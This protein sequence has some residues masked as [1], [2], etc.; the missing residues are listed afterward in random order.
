MAECLFWA[1]A[2]VC[3]N[4]EVLLSAI[5]DILC[6]KGKLWHT[7]QNSFIDE[8]GDQKIYYR[9]TW[10][11][12]RLRQYN[13]H[14]DFVNVGIFDVLKPCQ[15]GQEF[16]VNREG[17]H[18][19]QFLSAADKELKI[20]HDVVGLMEDF[21][22]QTASIYTLFNKL[23]KTLKTGRFLDSLHNFKNFFDFHTAVFEYKD[24]DRV[25]VSKPYR[26][27]L[28]TV[29]K[30]HM[31]MR[32]YGAGAAR[33]LATR[34][35]WKIWS[36]EDKGKNPLTSEDDMICLMRE[37]PFKFD[38][39]NDLIISL[40]LPTQGEDE[41]GVEVQGPL[42]SLAQA[43]E[44]IHNL[45]S[46]QSRP[47]TL[48]AIRSS[49]PVD[50]QVVLNE[51]WRMK[52]IINMNRD[53][54]VFVNSY[55]VKMAEEHDDP[56][57]GRDE[58]EDVQ[59]EEFC[60]RDVK[61]RDAV[62][63]ALQQ[64]GTGDDFSINVATLHK[65]LSIADNASLLREFKSVSDLEEFLSA[66]GDFVLK[67]RE[68][69]LKN[70][71]CDDDVESVVSSVASSVAESVTK[72][73]KAL[74]ETDVRT[75]E[76]L[77]LSG[78]YT[79]E[80][81]MLAYVD[82]KNHSKGNK[83]YFKLEWVMARFLPKIKRQLKDCH[84]LFDLIRNHHASKFTAVKRGKQKLI[85]L[86]DRLAE[87]PMEETMVEVIHNLFKSSGMSRIPAG[88][89]FELLSQ[90]GKLRVKSVM[91]FPHFVKMHEDDFSV[92]SK[93]IIS[94][95]TLATTVNK[96]NQSSSSM[97][98]ESLS[99]SSEVESRESSVVPSEHG[100]FSEQVGPLNPDALA[101][102]EELLNSAPFTADI[103]K[104]AFYDHK[105]HSKGNKVYFKLDWVVSFSPIQRWISTLGTKLQ[106][107][108]DKECELLFKTINKYHS[109]E[110][111]LFRSIAG[112]KKSL[113]QTRCNI[114]RLPTEEETLSELHKQ[115]ESAGKSTISSGELFSSL[116]RKGRLRIQGFS[117]F[118][119]FHSDDFA[120]A[121]KFVK[122]KKFK[123]PGGPCG[124]K[125]ASSKQNG[126]SDVDSVAGS[127]ASLG[128]G[129]PSEQIKGLEASA[130]RF[131]EDL[132][133]TSP[134]KVDS[135]KIAYFDHKD[136]SKGNKIYFRLDWVFS[137]LHP[138]VNG[139]IKDCGMLLKIISTYH[140][141][142]FVLFKSNAGPEKS[143][144][145]TKRFMDQLPSDESVV[146][147]LHRAFVIAGQASISSATLFELLSTGGQLRIKN[148][149][150]FADFVRFHPEEFT[151]EDDDQNVRDKKFFVLS[152]VHISN[153]K[154]LIESSHCTKVNSA[155]NDTDPN[156]VI[157]LKLD[158]V[159]DRIS[160][161]L[162][163]PD[164]MT[165]G[166]KLG[167]L[168]NENHLAE[169]HVIVGGQGKSWLIQTRKKIESL[170]PEMKVAEEVKKLVLGE[171]NNGLVDFSSV[172]KRLSNDALVRIRN[173][174]DWK[175]FID[176]H[177]IA[178]PCGSVMA[179]ETLSLSKILPDKDGDCVG[180]V[181]PTSESVTRPSK[182]SSEQNPT[183]TSPSPPGNPIAPPSKSTAGRTAPFAVTQQ[184][185]QQAQ[186]PPPFT[187]K[188]AQPCDVEMVDKVPPKV[189]PSQK[190]DCVS[191]MLSTSAM[192]TRPSES[193]SRENSILTSPSPPVNL[194]GKSTTSRMAPSAASQQA[195]QQARPQHPLAHKVSR[196]CDS[197]MVD[198]DQTLSNSLSSQTGDGVACTRPEHGLVARPSELRS[199]SNPASTSGHTSSLPVS[200][201]SRL[202]TSTLGRTA[203]VATATQSVGREQQ[204][205]FLY[206]GRVETAAQI[207]TGVPRS[208]SVSYGGPSAYAG[209]RLSPG[210]ARSSG[211]TPVRPTTSKANCVVS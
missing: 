115:F 99:E 29:N 98:Q 106:G 128:G 9:K 20:V 165:N 148:A 51:D 201:V 202:N 23:D 49:L 144:M 177:K 7:P 46:C 141:N 90:K 52:Q 156:S 162:N 112:A 130:V 41:E 22:Q 104:V 125:S 114:D 185:N 83:V 133:H 65:V 18:L 67:G 77:L 53:S 160:K 147:E 6:R 39:S 203:P 38:C 166:Q 80:S 188:V 173:H 50:Y 48:H 121:D 110:I 179:N 164:G 35:L 123:G 55:T 93:N 184:A 34:A 47:M 210:V 19:T 169:F 26:D 127:V 199:G 17:I 69:S 62:K 119:K 10:V 124:K 74:S 180:G 30:M 12:G 1:M 113:I 15:E 135:C 171:G 182:S 76:G 92:D 44:E 197:G 117:D 84:E 28:A 181:L 81:C 91:C 204:S 134:F 56:S 66:H 4:P 100:S 96:K 150:G 102:L 192:I 183:L 107:Q 146:E 138:K 94:D 95:R 194:P 174:D 208:S 200:P 14:N 118:V 89:L 82:T 187:H 36:D 63:R 111:V 161:R 152:D 54:F 122:D 87:L 79:N 58:E 24:S 189:L 140:G 190:K 8:D 103:C 137:R 132:L 78:Q 85:Q 32:E 59:V 172:K 142:N 108:K 143:L 25:K 42:F 206:S 13:E 105:D 5:K 139:K 158:W 86:K 27:K 205:P 70:E 168:I 167:K 196:P 101:R 207:T 170:P 40:I 175:H 33:S 149:R 43:K 60:K 151:V 131:I 61:V 155:I 71:P 154:H 157:Y 11:A 198:N 116:S 129:K 37:F 191:G 145:Q 21:K 68:V 3:T 193:S 211:S 72:P 186:P 126:S 109:D 153:L 73:G 136:Q 2:F 97:L 159:W 195:N 75:L 120:I 31:L 178:W 16:K 88:Q 45:L 163:F 176:F 57:D 209:Y 64:F